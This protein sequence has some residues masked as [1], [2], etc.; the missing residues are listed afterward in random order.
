M[1]ERRYEEGSCSRVSGPKRGTARRRFFRK[2]KSVF[3]GVETFGINNLRNETAS[4]RTLRRKTTGNPFVRSIS[5]RNDASKRK[6]ILAMT[7]KTSSMRATLFSRE[8][9]IIKYFQ[10]IISP[11]KEKYWNRNWKFIDLQAHRLSFRRRNLAT[12]DRKRILKMSSRAKNNW[13]TISMY[14]Y[15]PL[16]KRIFIAT[17]IYNLQKKKGSKQK[18][19]HAREKFSA[20]SQQQLFEK[21]ILLDRVDERDFESE[22]QRWSMRSM[23]G[24]VTQRVAPGDSKFTIR[25]I[26]RG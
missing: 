1:V 6:N 10:N 26:E 2:G 19:I 25:S 7:F 8:F 20:K 21:N 11:E 13:T 23:L 3:K 22:K 18:C 12:I 9:R 4:F 24:N 14:E 16:W 17:L 15:F 5:P